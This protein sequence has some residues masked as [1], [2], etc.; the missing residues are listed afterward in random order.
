MDLWHGCTHEK[1]NLSQF[2]IVFQT[3]TSLGNFRDIQRSSSRKNSSQSL[4]LEGLIRGEFKVYLMGLLDNLKIYR[5]MN[6]LPNSRQGVVFVDGDRLELKWISRDEAEALRV[7]EEDGGYSSRHR[8]L[9]H[10]AFGP[11]STKFVVRHRSRIFTTFAGLKYV[12]RLNSRKS[13]RGTW[14]S[15]SRGG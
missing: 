13:I 3:P 1:I 14:L 5:A 9:G 12:V 8:E 2:F 15:P 7:I 4:I 11:Q 10:P 6:N